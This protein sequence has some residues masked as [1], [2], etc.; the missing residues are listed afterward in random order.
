MNHLTLNI[1]WMGQIIE[2]IKSWEIEMILILVCDSCEFLVLKGVHI[3]E[4]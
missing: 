2:M 3:S 4:H 1:M